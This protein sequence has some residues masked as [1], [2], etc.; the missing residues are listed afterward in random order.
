MA[1]AQPLAREQR[2]R[3]DPEVLG[4]DGA[5]AH[6]QDAHATGDLGG[7]VLAGIEQCV[8]AFPQRA[9]QLGKDPGLE[10]GDQAVHGEQCAQF[11]GAETAYSVFPLT[12][13]PEAIL[14]RVKAR[15]KAAQAL[16]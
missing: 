13:V 7:G 9:D 11:A 4:L 10:I 2:G 12:Y 8:Q 6:R 15:C 1:D 16:V 3:E 5:G 14:M